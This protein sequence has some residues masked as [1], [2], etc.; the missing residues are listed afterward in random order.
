MYRR[1][2]CLTL[3]T[4][5][6][7][8][9]LQTVNSWATRWTK[10]SR[11]ADFCGGTRSESESLQASIE[12]HVKVAREHIAQDS[13]RSTGPFSVSSWS[14]RL[15]VYGTVRGTAL[16]GV[17]GLDNMVVVKNEEI[18]YFSRPWWVQPRGWF[19]SQRGQRQDLKRP[20][21]N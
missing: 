17:Y 12:P 20:T 6:N 14:A 4:T 19:Q 3:Y 16:D 1:R 21:G 10:T 5:K 11:R 8:A 7:V 2:H 13:R 18:I 15:T 9:M